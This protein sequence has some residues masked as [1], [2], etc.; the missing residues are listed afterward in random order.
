MMDINAVI[1]HFYKLL[2]EHSWSILIL[3]G[4]VELEVF[5]PTSQKPDMMPLVVPVVALVLEPFQSFVDK[6]GRLFLIK[7]TIRAR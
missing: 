1:D 3:K 2:C 5:L 4:L 7:P 6:I